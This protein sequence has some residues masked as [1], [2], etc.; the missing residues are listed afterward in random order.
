MNKVTP[1]LFGLA[2]AGVTVALAAVLSCALLEPGQERPTLHFA[3][4]QE[5]DQAATAIMNAKCASC[6]GEKPEYNKWLNLLAF[7]QLR[8]DVE[9]A[10]RS[11]VMKEDGSLRS[12]N[13]DYLKMDYVLRTYRMPPSQYSIVHLGSRLTPMDVAV[14]RSRYS[15]EGSLIRM[16]SP[17]EPVQVAPKERARVHLGKLLF[18]D[19]R[20]STNNAIAC[21][22]CHDLTKGG[23]DNKPKS[24][25]VPGPD[26]KPQLGGVN[27]PTVYNAAGHIR[28]FWDGRAATLREQAGGPPLN[29]VEMG[30]QSP[31][32]WQKIADKL[33]QCGQ[34]N[35][36][37]AYVY[38]EEGIT[39]DTITDAIAAYERTLVTPDSAFD[40]YLKGDM[41]ALTEEQ[42]DG[43][44]A[45]VRYGCATCHSGPALGGLSFEYINTHAPLRQHAEGYQESAFGRKDDT[46]K[47]EHQDMFRVPGLRNVALTAPYFH[48]GTV[49]KLSEAV[50]IMFETQ[51]GR[52]PSD[53]TISDV[54]RF[55]EAQT[56]KL[57]GKPLDQLTPSDV[58]PHQPAMVEP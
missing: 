37:F 46:G 22:T 8:R 48:T 30:Y 51:V 53:S 58:V 28:Q 45:F 4:P 16:F 52:V 32:D 35:L 39:Q 33:R 7:G 9:G 55:L 40:L 29:P 31:E 21:A 13:V 17:L 5:A 57:E 42:K 15:E 25:G 56:G 54:T 34:L 12:G 41:K 11:F 24:E 27:A 50:R 19:T 20:L 43:L 44:K 36:L 2:A 1:Y 26:G 6:H 18:N 23:T 47:E 10:Q 14:L 38:G 49:E 3:T